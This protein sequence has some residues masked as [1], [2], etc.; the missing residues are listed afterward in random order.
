MGSLRFR[1]SRSL[2]KGVR[3]N[4]NKRSVGMS[5]GVRGARY[6]MS[7]SGRRTTSVGIP[8]TGLYSI[9]SSGGGG[10][11]QFGKSGARGRST[12]ARPGLVTITPEMADQIIPKPNFLASA[13]ERRFRE[14]L[15]AYVKQQWELAASAFEQ[16]VAA[17]SKNVS[18]D[19]LLGACYVRLKRSAEAITVFE[20][21]IASPIALPDAMMSKYV[22]GTLE[23]Q[24]PITERVTASVAFDSVGATLILV[25]LYQEAGRLSEAIGLVQQLLSLAPDDPTLKLSLVDL[26]YD[27]DD[28]AGL[29]EAA[30]G[31]ENTDD[32][33][34]AI[35]HLKAKALANQGLIAPAAELL[36]ACLRRTSGRDS[37]LLKEVRYNRAEA[38]ELLDD[39]RKA[40]ADWTKLVAADPFYRDARQRLEALA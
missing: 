10:G 11:R 23:M 5:F 35:L 20:R 12:G 36:T 32:I 9:S 37:E 31:M 17:D 15:V 33:G 24:L 22:P 34:L 29:V 27:D 19:F 8:G 16:A 30:D 1:K 39:K 38:Y 25:E 28:F 18:D 2:G 21:V 7:S 40:K 13:A 26:L 3:L 14:G 4:L 6:S